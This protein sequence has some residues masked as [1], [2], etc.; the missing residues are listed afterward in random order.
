M[1]PNDVGGLLY[2]ITGKTTGA[3]SVDTVWNTEKIAGT[4]ALKRSGVG[5]YGRMRLATVGG[6]K[7]LVRITAVNDPVQVMRVS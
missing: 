2:K 1:Q 5:T 4:G 7:V 6:K 3:L